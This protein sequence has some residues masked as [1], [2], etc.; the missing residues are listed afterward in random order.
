ML[1]LAILLTTCTDENEAPENKIPEGAISI[2]EA[3][4][5]FEEQMIQ[6]SWLWLRI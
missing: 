3:K 5:F 1:A 2:D 4:T 6:K